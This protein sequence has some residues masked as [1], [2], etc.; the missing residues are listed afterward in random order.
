[1]VRSCQTVHFR[2]CAVYCLQIFPQKETE[3]PLT[4]TELNDIHGKLLGKGVYACPLLSLKCMPSKNGFIDR[5][6]N[7]DIYDG[8]SSHDCR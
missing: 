3:E 1:M 5:C 8:A 4:S 6:L 7:R 2:I